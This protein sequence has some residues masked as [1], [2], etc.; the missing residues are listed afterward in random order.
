MDLLN[1]D[2][3]RNSSKKFC[4]NA[5]AGFRE[6]HFLL[7]LASGADTQVLV[8]TPEHAKRLMQHLTH[9]VSSYEKNHGEIKAEWNPNIL[10]PFQI[11]PK[12]GKSD[13]GEGK[14]G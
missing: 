6:D 8:F 4:D 14:T 5:K 11:S 12:G 2:L 9:V 3:F 13:N 10:S 1:E 7:A